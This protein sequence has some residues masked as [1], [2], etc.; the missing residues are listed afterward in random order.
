[1][2]TIAAT[3][4]LLL[5]RGFF[6]EAHSLVAINLLIVLFTAFVLYISTHLQKAY[7]NMVQE[8]LSKSGGKIAKLNAIEILSQKGHGHTTDILTEFLRNEKDP[9]IMTKA[10]YALEKIGNLRAIPAILECLKSGDKK[11][12]IAAI[13]A[14]A[15][16]RGIKK[17]NGGAI[18]SRHKVIDDLKAI[19]KK[20]AVFEIKSAALRAIARIDEN[21]AAFLLNV[22]N[23]ACPRMQAECIRFMGSFADP[24]VAEYLHPFLD[25]KNPFVRAQAIVLTAKSRGMD[26]NLEKMID[27]MI[28]SK[29]KNVITASCIVL[30]SLR[31]SRVLSYAVKHLNDADEDIALNA[32]VGLLEAGLQRGGLRL[33]D[34]LLGGNELILDKAKLVLRNLNAGAVRLM[35][36]ILQRQVV[37]RAGVNGAK[38]QSVETLKQIDD[39]L[40]LRLMKSF[41]ALG[42][43]EEEEL[44]RNIIEHRDFLKTGSK[45]YKLEAVPE[46]IS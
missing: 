45:K 27:S 30:T 26:E 41:G 9:C 37:K 16:F 40:L 46:L 5:I 43:D 19:Y 21:A 20:T 12:V 24:V 38:P 11:V 17:R 3:L 42:L 15:D 7:T 13:D 33:A 29:E 36:D 4:L 39:N 18:F 31:L 22:L 25:A 10:I 2:G 32:A 28:N 34:L 1:V 23:E 35:S 8:N 44:I 6:I 14:L